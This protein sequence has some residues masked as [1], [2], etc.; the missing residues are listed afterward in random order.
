MLVDVRKLSTRHLHKTLATYLWS[1]SPPKRTDNFTTIVVC[2]LLESQ[3]QTSLPDY[4]LEFQIYFVYLRIVLSLVIYNSN[5]FSVFFHFFNLMFCNL[6]C[7]QH[8][9][10]TAFTITSLL[11]VCTL[12]VVFIETPLSAISK[13]NILVHT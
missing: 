8:A 5:F 2:S 9:V 7:T 12:Y 6:A 11:Y 4:K 3:F 1:F 13:I 10:I